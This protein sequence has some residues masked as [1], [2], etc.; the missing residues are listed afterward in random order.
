[1]GSGR[2]ADTAGQEVEVKF[3]IANME[4][5]ERRL[6]ALDARL[7][8]PRTLELNHRFDTP[9]ADLAR[10]QQVLRLRQDSS[11]R[12]TYKGAGILESGAVRRQEIE[13]GVSDFDVGRELLAALGF[14]VV[15]I[16]EKYRRTY[17]VSG[18]A[19]AMLDE[20]PYGDFLEIEGEVRSL[21][22][23][24]AALGVEWAAAIPLS[25]HA[26]FHTLK[27]SRRL[28]FRDLTF[29]NFRGIIVTPSDLGLRPADI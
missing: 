14:E 22:S 9:L 16:Y 4:V 13:L 23:I 20:L 3:L 6:Q 8:Q 25:Y 12:L 1:M 29:D 19:H 2:G 21:G 10:S 26:I 15:F 28:P 17:S 18:A 27:Q 24:A 11:V 7:V 5:L